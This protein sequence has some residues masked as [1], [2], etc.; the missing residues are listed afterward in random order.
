MR[1]HASLWL[2]LLA[3]GSAGADESARHWAYQP[4]VRSAVPRVATPG[5]VR[6]AVDSF[7]LHRLEEAGIEPNGEADRHTLLRRLY[8]DLIGLPPSYEAARD[9]ESDPSP[10]AYEKIVDRLLASPLYGQRWGRHWLDVARYADTMGYNFTSDPR[11]PFAWTYRD[12]VVD[13]FNADLPYDRFLLEQIAG[14][15]LDQTGT[16]PP[17]SLAAMGFLSVGRRFDF[18]IHATIDDRIDVVTRGL[19]GLTVQCARCHDHLYDPITQADYYALYG[20]FRSSKEPPTEDQ[21]IITE[22]DGAAMARFEAELAKRQKELDDY[23]AALHESIQVDARSRAAEY[24]A[25]AAGKGPIEGLRPALIQRFKT[26]WDKAGSPA[27]PTGEQTAAIAEAVAALSRDEARALVTPAEVGQIAQLKNKVHAWH[28]ESPDAPARAMVVYDAEALFEPYVF[29]RGQPGSRGPKVPRRFLSVLAPAVGNEPFNEG[30]GRLDLARAIVHPANPLTPRVMVNRVWQWHFGQGLVRTA[31]DF[32]SRG[33]PPSHPEL[34]D[35]LAAEFIESGWSVKKLHRAIVLSATYRQSSAAGV[36][37][38]ARPMVDPENRLL[39]R[40][41]RRRLEFEPMRDSMLHV[42]GRLDTALG[43]RPGSLVE[44]PYTTRRS[45][46]GYIDRQYLDRTLRTFDFASPDTSEPSRP[47]TTVPQQSLFLMNSTFVTDQVQHLLARPQVRDA[48]DD[49][50]KIRQI[51][52]LL[53]S[54]DPSQD[55]V[56]LGLEFLSFEQ[57][58]HTETQLPPWVKYAQALMVSNEFMFV[59]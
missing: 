48:P 12:Y 32:G 1:L 56:A 16:R 31:S 47:Q 14:D 7:V 33:E 26:E 38:D 20:V 29:H 59:D 36:A 39:W 25:A 57:R 52:R 18:D 41:E 3:V 19:M 30:S 58:Q 9:F 44:P 50:S 4:I 17:R 35:Y 21:P 27:E 45:V 15:W 40:F 42:G 43:G 10:D 5:S 6:T 34:L 24:F 2:I 11:Y 22:P 46:Y 13:A 54:R 37:T 8:L 55:E 23:L 53:F 49:A 51:Y 28:I